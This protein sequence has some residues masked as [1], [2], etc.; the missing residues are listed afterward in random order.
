MA[1]LLGLDK[2]RYENFGKRNEYEENNDYDEPEDEIPHD[3]DIHFKT[4]CEK[5]E[6]FVA[7]NGYYNT[8]GNSGLFCNTCNE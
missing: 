3:D 8:K 7:F 2:S 4:F 6:K 5:C 1:K